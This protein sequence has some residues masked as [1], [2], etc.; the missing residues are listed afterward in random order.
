MS[1]LPT[2]ILLA[3]DGAEDAE[4]AL[5][6]AVDL[7][8][9]TNSELHVVHVGRLLG[10]AGAAINRGALPGSQDELDREAQRCW[11]FRYRRSK[12]PEVP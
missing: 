6:V 9:S 4:L 12:P 5:R 10:Y 11:R 3:T 1:L 2:K 7:T 8:S